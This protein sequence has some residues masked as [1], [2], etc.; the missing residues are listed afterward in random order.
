[1]NRKIVF[2]VQ[3]VFESGP[4]YYLRPLIKSLVAHSVDI[5][6]IVLGHE[7]SAESVTTEDRFTVHVVPRTRSRIELVGAIRQLIQQIDPAIIHCWGLEPRDVVTAARL[8]LMNSQAKLVTTVFET[9]L[10]SQ[11]IVAR[12]IS[13]CAADVLIANHRSLVEPLAESGLKASQVISMNW[14]PDP[15]DLSLIHI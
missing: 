1:M 14:L 6:V 4:F 3:S 9:E 5:E 2:V 8:T 15:V 11:S 7:V 13:R 10:E 12:T